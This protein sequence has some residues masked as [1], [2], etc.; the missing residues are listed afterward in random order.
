MVQSG[1]YPDGTGGYTG[2]GKF[3]EGNFWLKLGGG[4]SG[5]VDML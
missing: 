5:I 1:G 4:I 3:L 2:F